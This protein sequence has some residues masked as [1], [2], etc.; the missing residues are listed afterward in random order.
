M[1]DTE[2]TAVLVA[3]S[4]TTEN[5]TSRFSA[6]SLFNNTDDLFEFPYCNIDG[7]INIEAQL[8]S[9]LYSIAEFKGVAAIT[10]NQ[11]KACGSYS[12]EHENHLEVINAYM[13]LL[14][15]EPQ[16]IEK[17]SGMNP[18][19]REFN[20]LDN[21]PF[22]GN[23]KI[24]FEDIKKQL[25]E[26]ALSP[27]T[28]S[29]FGEE[30][31]KAIIRQFFPKDE[32][33][34]INRSVMHNWAKRLQNCGR[35]FNVHEYMHP[36]IAIDL[37]ILGYTN[38]DIDNKVKEEACILLTKRKK[39]L[40]LGDSIN[41]IW[42]GWSLPGTFLRSKED[43][44]NKS[45]LGLE[46]IQ[47]ATA[48]VAKEKTGIDIQPDDILHNIKPFVHHSRMNWRWRD[49]SPVI[50]LPVILPI[51]HCEII[52]KETLTTSESKW[53]PIKRMLWTTNDE[54]Q[55]GLKKV[56]LRGGDD[57][58]KIENGSV[59]KVEAY[60][61][62]NTGIYKWEKE[63]CE[64]LT[65]YNW[66]TTDNAADSHISYEENSN[67]I[68]RSPDE[69]GLHAAD[70]YIKEEKLCIDYYHN[71]VSPHR[72]VQDWNYDYVL[73]Q[74]G[75]SYPK[76]PPA[77][78]EL[79]IAD[80]AN[81]IIS[82]L[83]EISGNDDLALNILYRLLKGVTVRP[84]E[85]TK[86]LELLFF[87]WSFSQSTMHKKLTTK[88]LTPAPSNQGMVRKNAYQFKNE[89]EFAQF[90]KKRKPFSVV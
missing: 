16:I 82:A 65:N 35:D 42:E 56:A 86:M 24:I 18:N 3:I 20:K 88:L 47:E 49:G 64:C 15:G 90:M 75:K 5:D 83:Q 30:T 34:K 71:I 50:T 17:G 85:V 23:H 73:D 62:D 80:H 37:I 38:P 66:G 61:D 36:G 21:L 74:N 29:L 26:T 39:D 33:G 10:P 63:K 28:D 22:F 41:D 87:P 32:E 4:S 81:I 1:K 43:P 13:V 45:V 51:R 2:N 78:T 84:I 40:E 69:I 76:L 72:P 31:A 57:P 60:E 55:G 89:E 11:L 79:L 25:L 19:W 77:G 12:I 9:T 48:R 6:F 53:F 46:T 68:L 54:V 44:E 58:L 14:D 27:T 7:H 52:S 70:V 8:L 59:Q 67:S